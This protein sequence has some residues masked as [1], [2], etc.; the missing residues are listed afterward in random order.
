[1]AV[2]LTLRGEKGSPLTN[3]EVDT[4]F[5]NLKTEVELKLNSADFTGTNVLNLI[6]G[7]DGSGSLL[8]ADRVDGLEQ[9]SSLPTTTDK[10]SIVSRDADGDF[11]VGTVSG[12][13]Q[14]TGT[15]TFSGKAA[16][17]SGTITGITALGLAEGG[18]GGSTASAARESMGLEIGVDVQEW[19]AVLDDIGG[20]TQ[21]ANKG[22]Y[23]DSATTASTFTITSTARNLLDDTSVSAMRSTLGLAIGTNVQGYDADL[24]GLAAL[25]TPN[26]GQDTGAVVRTGNGS[27]A[28]KSISGGGGVT[29]TEDS[30]S[31]TI[32]TG[33]DVSTSGN[34]RF[35]SLGIGT[36]AS[37]TAGEIRATNQITSYYSDERL[38]TNI[39]KI[40]S[41]LDKVNSLRG[42]T[43]NPNQ[44]AEGFGYDSKSS[45]VGVIAQDV[46]Q[47]LPEAVKPAPFDRMLFEGKEISK[48]G[49]GYLTVQYEKLVPLLVEAIKELTEEV[50]RL[51]DK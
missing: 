14:T 36:N 4:N 25:S 18:T 49:E 40:D 13:F 39:V 19:S 9:S 51:K 6:K 41:A 45:E 8:D 24:A 38:K 29:V 32:A 10:S 48:S 50:N 44:I 34:V 7:V 20:V 3:S 1:M 37:G 21:A 43:Y 26:S 28:T 17:T 31:I 46:Q 27:Y 12:S 5:S 35:N 33:Q 11:E 30:T 15:G 23:F 47:V 42:V 2:T 16:I 22:I